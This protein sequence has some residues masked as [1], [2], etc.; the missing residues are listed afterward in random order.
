MSVRIG[1]TRKLEVFMAS[2]YARRTTSRIDGIRAVNSLPIP[3]FVDAP[4]EALILFFHQKYLEP[5]GFRQIPHQPLQ[6]EITAPERPG[7]ILSDFS[8]IDRGQRFCPIA[9]HRQN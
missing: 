3:W 2:G 1:T 6:R 8:W 9:D 4:I 5:V 7:E